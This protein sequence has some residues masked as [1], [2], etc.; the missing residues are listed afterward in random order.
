MSRQGVLAEGSS[1]APNILFAWR[2]TTE[3]PKFQY[4]TLPEVDWDALWLGSCNRLLGG[5]PTTSQ[6]AS[7]TSSSSDSNACRRT[8]FHRPRPRCLRSRRA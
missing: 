1:L 2:R 5:Q 8:A 7:A 3:A 4:Q 6:L